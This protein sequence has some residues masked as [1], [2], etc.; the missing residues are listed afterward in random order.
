MCKDCLYGVWVIH[1]HTAEKRQ[2]TD[3]LNEEK[4]DKMTLHFAALSLQVFNS[5]QKIELFGLLY[6]LIFHRLFTHVSVLF[7][8]ECEIDIFL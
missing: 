4:K 6:I 5:K 1:L 2:S 8:I 3:A 7:L